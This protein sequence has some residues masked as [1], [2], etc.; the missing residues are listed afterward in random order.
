MRAARVVQTALAAIQALTSN[1]WVRL[2]R[3]V[4]CV[5]P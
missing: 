3:V 5:P 2:F 1:N 4:R